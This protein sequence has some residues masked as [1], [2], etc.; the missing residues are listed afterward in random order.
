MELW[1]LKRATQA[2]CQKNN[3]TTTFTLPILSQVYHKII[4]FQT[5]HLREFRTRNLK[6]QQQFTQISESQNKTQGFQVNQFIK[7]KKATK[8]QKMQVNSENRFKKKE[9]KIWQ[10][11]PDKLSVQMAVKVKMQLSLPT[12]PLHTQ[13]SQITK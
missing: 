9:E 8:A 11:F 12:D 1:N 7:Q 3:L 10:I 13:L 4:V 5:A 6:V 2:I